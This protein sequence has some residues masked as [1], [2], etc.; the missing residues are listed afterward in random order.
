MAKAG[1]FAQSID[2]FTL[3]FIGG[4]EKAVRSTTGILWGDIIRATPVDSGRAR[5]NWFAT[6][7]QP[8]NRTTDKLDLS[9]NSAALN[10]QKVVIGLKNWSSF[11]LTNNLPY[12]NVLEFG[13]YGDG[14]KTSGGFSKQAPA[15]MLRLN[16]LRFNNLLEAN[17]KKHLPK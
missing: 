13:G 10:A 9:G 17:A 12:I 14:P 7:Q 1:M 6:G 2:E 3:N 5:G 15:G 8:S 16:V 4:S 11:T